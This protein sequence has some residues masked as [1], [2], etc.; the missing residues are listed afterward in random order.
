MAAHLLIVEASHSAVL[1]VFFGFSSLVY[2][3]TNGPDDA[4]QNNNNEQSK[5]TV[6][7]TPPHIV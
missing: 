3:P 2:K 7:V 6:H 5:I 4:N 1:S